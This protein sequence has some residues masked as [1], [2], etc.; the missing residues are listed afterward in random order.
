MSL[1]QRRIRHKHLRVL[2]VSSSLKDAW[3]SYL[4]LASIDPHKKRR[5]F[6]PWQYLHRIVR[7]IA[8]TRPRVR[9]HFE[10]LL[11]VLSRIHE[12]GGEVQTWEWNLLI[13]A[14]GKGLRK[15][16]KEQF[17][18]VLSVY[19]DFLRHRPPGESLRLGTR[20][21][22]NVFQSSE[23]LR[24]P[25]EVM[26]AT[27]LHLASRTSDERAYARGLSLLHA[28]GLRINRPTYLTLMERHSHKGNL[29]GVRAVMAEMQR[30]DVKLG[31]EGWTLYMWTL[32][33][34]DRIDQAQRV[35]TVLR[36]NQVPQWT[37]EV[38]VAR[39]HLED[40]DVDIPT[41]VVPDEVTYI[42]MIQAYAY[43][44][45]FTKAMKTFLEMVRTFHHPSDNTEDN[46]AIPVE[47]LLPMYRAMFLG[48]NR[49][50]QLDLPN[51]S[52]L[53]R[54]SRAIIRGAEGWSLSACQK[55]FDDWLRLPHKTK[56]NAH[57]CYWILRAF[58]TLSG[59]NPEFLRDVVE[60][61]EARFGLKWRGRLSVFIQSKVN[62]RLRRN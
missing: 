46:S 28:S 3:A 11:Q 18:D 21:R 30:R 40:M 22:R 33:R 36:G 37:N 45:H 53:V 26:L 6:I 20:T 48:F 31:V 5:D 32:V 17:K 27:V 35:F 50:S 13:D 7:V 12:T 24:K 42:A 59:G 44:G 39:A 55:L 14:A 23:D 25:N 10:C 60:R 15:T 34:L 49:H 2:A 51:L 62:N 56:P 58:D 1:Q 19:D 38:R 8:S 16:T 61:L 57:T 43:Y 52:S 4:A 29:P 54:H 41:D 9:V 47:S